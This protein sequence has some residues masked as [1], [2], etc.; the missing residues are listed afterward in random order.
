MA[1]ERYFGDSMTVTIDTEDTSPVSVPV[2]SLQQVQIIANAEHVELTSADTTKRD[3]VAKRNFGVDVTVGVAAFDMTI[4]EEWLGGDGSSS[5]SYTDDNSV[6]LF[7]VAGSVTGSDGTTHTATVDGVYFPQ[8]PIIDA[9]EGQWVRHNV[10]GDG[11]D[12]TIS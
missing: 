11:A 12:V 6:A 7:T 3:D 10:Q 4:V 9:Q 2:G 8:M 1:A 5:S